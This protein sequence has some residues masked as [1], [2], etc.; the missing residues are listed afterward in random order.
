MMLL[1]LLLFLVSLPNCCTSV[2]FDAVLLMDASSFSTKLF[3]SFIISLTN[4]TTVTLRSV[5]PDTITG[6]DGK[7]I[8]AN[9]S[10]FYNFQLLHVTRVRVSVSVKEEQ[11][12][13]AIVRHSLPHE[14]ALRGLGI[15]GVEGIVI[16]SDVLPQWF[17]S[18]YV[19]LPSFVAQYLVLGWGLTVVCFMSCIMCYCCCRTRKKEPLIPTAVTTHVV[20]EIAPKAIMDPAAVVIVQTAPKTPLKQAIQRTARS[21]GLAEAL[22]QIADQT[23]RDTDPD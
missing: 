17:T 13:S 15:V 6:M 11:T 16:E 1:L 10:S 14:A 7:R 18:T 2:V 19:E 23:K 9:S 3:T 8:F 4:A 12:V 5:E 20:P 22:R 21:N